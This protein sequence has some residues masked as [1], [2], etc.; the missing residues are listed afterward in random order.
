ML[1]SGLDS[2]IVGIYKISFKNCEVLNLSL[3]KVS[4]KVL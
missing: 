3:V 4:H 1:W 2:E